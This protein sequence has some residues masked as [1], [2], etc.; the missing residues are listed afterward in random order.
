V[1]A[2]RGG[3]VYALAGRCAHRGGSLADG[4][5]V[6]ECLQCPLHGSLFRLADGA[7]ER[8]PSAYPQ[9]VFDVRVAGGR[10]AVRAAAA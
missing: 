6:G 7:V 4:E 10:I 8:G 5:L 9:P 3:S 2:R 1:L